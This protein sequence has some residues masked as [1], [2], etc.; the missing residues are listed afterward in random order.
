MAERKQATITELQALDYKLA[1]LHYNHIF[2]LLNKFSFISAALP[3]AQICFQLTI[4]LLQ[5]TSFRKEF[6]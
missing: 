2:P 3:Y 6:T 5:G 1:N 4:Y